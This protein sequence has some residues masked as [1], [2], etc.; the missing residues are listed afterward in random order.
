MKCSRPELYANA[1]V[2]RK[3]ILMYIGEYLTKFGFFGKI[4]H[5][6]YHTP[7]PV[8]NMQYFQI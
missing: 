8:I 2:C 5:K 1:T 3:H 4:S 6:K 7:S